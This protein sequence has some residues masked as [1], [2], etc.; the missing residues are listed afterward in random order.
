M[1]NPFARPDTSRDHALEEPN[2]RLIFSPVTDWIVVVTAG[3]IGTCLILFSM[4]RTDALVHPI[5]PDVRSIAIGIGVFIGVVLAAVTTDAWKLGIGFSRPPRGP[6][7]VVS[8]LV[9]IGACGFGGNMLAGVAT[10]WRAFHGLSPGSHDEAFTVLATTA[11]MRTADWVDLRSEDGSAFSLNC[12][13]DVLGAL[14]V[15]DRIILPVETGRAGI[16]RTRLP[17]H[18]EDLKR[19]QPAEW[20]A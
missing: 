9:L 11:G 13:N 10:E 17:S 16:E 20:R 6:M 7:A 15:G 2:S 4:N 3:T 8:L 19:L 18:A 5:D 14:R 12:F 1:A